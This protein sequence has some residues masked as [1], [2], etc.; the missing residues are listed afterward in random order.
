MRKHR[1]GLLNKFGVWSYW[2]SF[3]GRSWRTNTCWKN[4]QLVTS[5]FIHHYLF[6]GF[7]NIWFYQFFPLKIRENLEFFDT[8]KN[9]PCVFSCYKLKRMYWYVSI[10]PQ[11]R[12]FLAITSNK[13]TAFFSSQ[14][15]IYQNFPYLNRNFLSDIPTWKLFLRL[16]EW[17]SRDYRMATSL[18]PL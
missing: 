3:H 14:N 10:Q 8:Y 4:V 5:S 7:W 2:C 6:F 12:S 13:K 16:E 11:Y 1:R 18:Y 9:L 17:F 15:S